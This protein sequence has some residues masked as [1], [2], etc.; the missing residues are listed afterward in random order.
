MRHEH[1]QIKQRLA[2][3]A[4]RLSA[5]ESGTEAGESDLH[6][7]RG[8]SCLTAFPAPLEAERKLSRNVP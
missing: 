1:Q 5:G 4:S 2:V 7:P 3:I 6:N 8:R